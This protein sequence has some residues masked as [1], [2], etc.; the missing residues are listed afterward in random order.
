MLFSTNDYSQN[1]RPVFASWM[2]NFYEPYFSDLQKCRQGIEELKSLGF[3]SIVL[4]SKL[5]TDFTAYFNGEKPSQYV[6]TQIE[7]IEKCRQLK[8]GTS[9]LALYYIGD[10]LYPEV[11]D[12]PPEY[13]EQPVALDGEKI[14]GYRHWSNKQLKRK[15]E[16]CLD[17]Y[18]KLAKDTAASAIDEN[19]NEKLPFYFYHDPVFTPIFDD[20]GIEHYKNWLKQNYTIQQLNAR[21]GINKRSIDELTPHDYWVYPE[22]GAARWDIPTTEDYQNKTVNVLKYADNQRYKIEVISN[23][24]AHLSQSLRKAEPRFYLYSSISQWKIFFND[25]RHAWFWDSSRRSTDIWQIGKSLDCPSFTTLP[26]DCFSQPDSYVVSAELAML[27]SATGFKD[28]LAG[29]FFGRY[30]YNDIYSVF[31]PEEI[32]TT[33]YGTGA[34][35]FYFYG[36]NGLDDGGNFGKWEKEKKDSVKKGLDWFTKLR[37]TTG[38]RKKENTAAII[39]PLATF[40][41][42]HAGYDWETYAKYRQDLLGWYKQFADMGINPDILH[43]DQVK[44]GL[45]DQYEIAIYPADPM[46]YAMPDQK[47]NDSIKEFVKSGK[48]IL[49]SASSPIPNILEIETKKHE[50]DPIVWE[51]KITTDSPIF[52]SFPGCQ[53]V[54]KYRGTDEPA[55]VTAE[56]EKGQVLLFGFDYGYSYASVMHLPSPARYGKENHYPLTMIERTPVEKLMKEKYPNLERNRNIEIVPFEKGTLIINHSAYNYKTPESRSGLCTYAGFDG[57][58]LPPHNSVFILNK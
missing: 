3:N 43:P 15:L 30:L 55:I 46:Y 1:D 39:F 17:L 36:Y 16:H 6:N 50:S 35:D 14:R 21:Y 47:L 38:P 20:D 28:F 10:N 11:Y 37:S 13:V 8:M 5:W 7:M 27:R 44:A 23:M 31:S 24:F 12:N 48:I 19:G 49:A 56:L 57:E 32:L 34:T 54:A 45:L 51:E 22:K 18:N 25:C 40:S 33:A 52:L 53:P 29:I 2:G 42:H 26:A 9:F 4:D 41:L 58:N